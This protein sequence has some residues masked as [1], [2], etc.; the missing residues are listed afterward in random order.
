MQSTIAGVRASLFA[1]LALI[2]ITAPA[3]LAQQDAKTCKAKTKTMGC[4]LEGIS[5]AARATAVA[6]GGP[7]PGKCQ[8]D[9]PGITPI[10]S[11]T[12][13][14]GVTCDDPSLGDT[15]D[16]MI[17]LCKTAATSA[18]SACKTTCS[19][20]EKIDST[21]GDPIPETPCHQVVDKTVVTTETTSPVVG[22]NEDGEDGCLI[23]CTASIVCVCD[24]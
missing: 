7:L 16:A 2:L 4:S 18:R 8:I 20:L 11:S 6:A 5:A 21:T 15:G 13:V 1:A 14:L 19:K 10:T 9:S 12:V 3:A 23:R 22:T 17:G 24:P